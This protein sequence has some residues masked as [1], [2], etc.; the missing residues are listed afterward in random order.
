MFRTGNALLIAQLLIAGLCQRSGFAEDWPHF[1]GPNCAGVSM[2]SKPLPAEFS[3]EKNVR[4]SEKL[5]DG[6][7]CPVV[8]AGRVFTSAMVDEKTMGL[9]AFDAASG[10]QLWL[11]KWPIGDIAPVHK[12][13]SHAATTPAADAERHI[14]E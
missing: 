2:A 1:R 12:T 7:G 14:H 13:N 5:G 8:A 4:W 9:Y 10:K 6:I 3:A 11:R